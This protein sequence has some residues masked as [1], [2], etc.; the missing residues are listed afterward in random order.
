MISSQKATRFRKEGKFLYTVCMKCVE[1]Y[2][3][4]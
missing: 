1:K 2:M 3:G 4:S